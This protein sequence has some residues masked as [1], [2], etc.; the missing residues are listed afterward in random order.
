M[1]NCCDVK[2]VSAVSPTRCP[3]CGSRGRLVERVTVKAMLKPEGLARLSA[4]GHRFCPTPRCPVVY[5]GIDEAFKQEE[6]VVPVYQKEPVGERIVCYCFA[7]GEGEIRRELAESGRS[8]SAER[9]T[10]LVKADRCACEVKNPQGSCC[11]GNLAA[12]AKAAKAA[13]DA[14]AAAATYARYTT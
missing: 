2:P 1:D 11:L 8:T 6:V 12:V 4:P 3:E 9:V 5:F 13:V 10:A 7:I 14:S